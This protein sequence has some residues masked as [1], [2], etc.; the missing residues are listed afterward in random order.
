MKIKK[1]FKCKNEKEI[2]EFYKHPQMPDGT[3]N[4]CKE[5]N[6]LDNKNSNGNQERK[7]TECNKIFFTRIHEI[8]RRGGGGKTCSR[9]CY[10]KR[11]R[12]II[13]KEEESKNWKGDSVGK[14]ALHD[15]V[16]KHLGKPRKCEHCQ[17]TESK[18]YDWANVSQT[19]KRDLKD[20]IRL[21]R[22]CHAKYDYKFRIEKWRQSVTKRGWKVKEL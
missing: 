4:K 13:K 6:K 5:C 18:L 20:W 3:V 7:C 2:S 21:C 17:S 16:I 11:L 8:K 19:Y 22:A 12:K 1:C 15:W 9:E 10:Y 14:S